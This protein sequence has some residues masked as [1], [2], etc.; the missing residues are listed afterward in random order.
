[1]GARNPRSAAPLVVSLAVLGFA[2]WVLTQGYLLDYLPTL[3]AH[4]WICIALATTGAAVA[5]I[6]VSAA[7]PDE[8][9]D[10]DGAPRTTSA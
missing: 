5:A 10:R 6:A 3:A 9:T 4:L 8:Q 1:M 2:V 7:L